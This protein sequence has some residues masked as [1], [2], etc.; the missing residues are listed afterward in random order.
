MNKN[1][2]AMLEVTERKLEE[3]AAGLARD[4]SNGLLAQALE[5][6]AERQ[7]D[8][9][10]HRALMREAASRL[11]AKGNDMEMAR[12]RI[13]GVAK[14]GPSMTSPLGFDERYAVQVQFEGDQAPTRFTVPETVGRALQA[15]VHDGLLVKGTMVLEALP[16]KPRR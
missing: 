8:N 11:A 1:E 5:Q 10:A 14:L 13:T 9:V 15:L 4:A 12:G 6:A 16:A 7:V 2:E 3:A